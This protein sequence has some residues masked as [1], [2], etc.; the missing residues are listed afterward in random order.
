MHFVA[1]HESG[2]GLKSRSLRY[3]AALKYIDSWTNP[4]DT[5]NGD[6]HRQWFNS[7]KGYGLIQPAGG[8]KEVF[9]HIS[10]SSVRV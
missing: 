6:R 3:V 5:Q 4:G 8:G 1:M 2:A 9:V 10:A 7:T